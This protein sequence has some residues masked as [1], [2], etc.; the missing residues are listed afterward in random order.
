MEGSLRAYIDGLDK[1]Q[2]GLLELGL[3]M[4]DL[5]PFW[6]RLVPVYI[7]WIGEQFDIEGAFFGSGWEALSPAYAA[8]KS[9]AFPGKRILSMMGPLRKAATSPTRYPGPLMLEL[10]I[11][12][13]EHPPLPGRAS[14]RRSA[15]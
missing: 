4:R 13:Y 7:S 2:K 14:E 12:P 10:R 6:P 11:N 9:V 3:A 1:A 5:R 15:R 8:W